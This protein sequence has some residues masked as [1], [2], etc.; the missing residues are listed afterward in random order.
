M[1]K[2]LSMLLIL[3]FLLTALMACGEEP[4]ATEGGTESGSESATGPI[5]QGGTLASTNE[6]G[7]NE[8]VP[9]INPDEHDYDGETIN[10]LARS[11]IPQYREW[12]KTEIGDDILDQAIKARNDIVASDLNIVVNVILKDTSSFNDYLEKF[13]AYIKNDVDL[14]LHE[15]DIV[16]AFA[17]GAPNAQIRDYLANM[18]NPAMFPYFDFTKPCWNQTLV[19]NITINNKLYYA[20][21]DINLS[22][23]DRR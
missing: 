21:S 10:I 6:H 22:V 7:D 3:C 18:A 8:F 15:Y 2:I 13:N 19:K 4:E 14:G 1:K 20:A 16:S 11:S 23:F 12:G 17:Y 9:T 5:E